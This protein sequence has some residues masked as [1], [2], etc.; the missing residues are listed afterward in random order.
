MSLRKLKRSQ[1][2][3][4]QKQLVSHY[5]TGHPSQLLQAARALLQ[6]GNLQEA[7]KA[8]KHIIMVF[9]GQAAAHNDL[10]ALYHSHGKLQEALLHYK[11]AITADGNYPQALTNSPLPGSGHQQ[12][13]CFL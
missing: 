8:Y 13:L 2:K 4:S 3:K 10:G 5:G 11:K 12:G 7:E 6:A 1:S 9:P